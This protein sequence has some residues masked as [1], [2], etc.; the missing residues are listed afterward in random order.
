ALAPV[1]CGP[2]GMR[3]ARLAC[4]GF[5]F[6]ANFATWLLGAGLPGLEA[7]ERYGQ[8]VL[9]LLAQGSAGP[10]DTLLLG[11]PLTVGVGDATVA[12][13]CFTLGT[14]NGVPVAHWPHVAQKARAGWADERI[15]LHLFTRP[16][17]S[18]P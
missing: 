10:R 9:D 15:L 4:L 11:V 14:H 2:H 7:V 1:L 18:L 8:P 13:R 17:R 6:P 5:R 16:V 12:A 3:L